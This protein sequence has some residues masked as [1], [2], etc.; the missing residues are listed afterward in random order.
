MS[1]SSTAPAPA[2]LDALAPIE[3]TPAT[4][5]PDSLRTS[6]NVSRKISTDDN[7]GPNRKRGR[8][9]QQSTDADVLTVLCE[10]RLIPINRGSLSTFIPNSRVIMFTTHLMDVMMANCR[11]WQSRCVIWNPIMSRIYVGIL[12]I[13]QT[14][15]CM[16][17]SRN[18]SQDMID[19]LENLERNVGWS[20]L[21]I[22]GPLATFFKAICVCKS[23]CSEYGNITPF[24]EHDPGSGNNTSHALSTL[25][26]S[27]I[28]C[29]TGLRRA[30]M[31]VQLADPVTPGNTRQWDYNL[32]TPNGNAAEARDA[33]S[34]H[35]MCRD[36]R[37]MPG[38]NFTP[39]FSGR[40]WNTWRLG[41]QI[42]P[43]PPVAHNEGDLT[44]SAF[45]GFTHGS[46]W[47]SRLA[48]L[49]TEYSKHWKGSCTMNDLAIMNGE[50]PLVLTKSTQVY[51]DANVSRNAQNPHDFSVT[52]TSL[53][54][55][56]PSIP[57]S[58]GMVSQINW[59]PSQDYSPDANVGLAANAGSRV[60]PWWTRSPNRLSSTE[61]DP[62]LSLDQVLA[63]RYYLDRPME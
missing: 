37:I 6:E 15:R 12:F 18:A 57:M 48:S 17:Y 3:S 8:I 60:G 59:V 19:I 61:Y 32:H 23:D 55:G 49:M 30:Y 20:K 4:T 10:N 40:Q 13:L 7:T 63:D 33:A 14:M 16:R 51:A 42:I 2:E 56:I 62:T 27:L 29:I 9:D 31:T 45:L 35:H 50:A 41:G 24:L 54:G 1:S 34:Q 5:G 22:P 58:I 11:Y 36:A 25:M 47:F 39:M 43:I 53:M 38:L 52:A 21:V 44:W 28:P 26:R 46:H